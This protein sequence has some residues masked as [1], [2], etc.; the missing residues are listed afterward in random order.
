MASISCVPDLEEASLLLR[1]IQPRLDVVEDDLS[2]MM[3]D[4][5]AVDDLIKTCHE[6][7]TCGHI[8]DLLREHVVTLT[9]A[10]RNLLNQKNT[11]K[12][13]NRCLSYI[14]NTF[15]QSELYKTLNGEKE[16]FSFEDSP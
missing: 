2:A 12:E 5:K 15:C 13:L 10:Q 9:K 6:N 8:D 16:D 11:E 7:C 14:Q 3:D 4:P 1:T